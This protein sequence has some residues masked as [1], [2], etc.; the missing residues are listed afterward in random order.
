MSEELID[1]VL[2]NT[3]PTKQKALNIA[4]D[5][6]LPLS[7]NLLSIDTAIITYLNE[8]INPVIVDDNDEVVKVPIIYSNP[9][10]WKSTQKDGFFKDSKGKI[11]LPV[12]AITRTGLEKSPDMGNAVNKHLVRSFM[13]GYSKN[14]TYDRFNLLNNVRPT[15]KLI[16]ITSP[17][18]VNLTYDCSIWTEKTEQ[19]NSVI[20]QINFES[21]EFWGDR[22]SFKFLVSIDSFSE[23]TELP[24]DENRTIRSTFTLK[25]RAYLLPERTVD[26]ADGPIMTQQDVYTIKKSIIFIEAVDKIDP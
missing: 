4:S 1:K 26:G 25:V 12:L 5:V 24:A 18:Y 11:M 7:V 14:Q 13:T 3:A 21:D 22:N 15:R 17:D 6:A 9:E 8:K 2:D 23:A 19:M 10:K 20:E 16:T